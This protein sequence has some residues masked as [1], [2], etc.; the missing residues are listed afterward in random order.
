L[1]RGVIEASGQIVWVLG[2]EDQR[3]RFLRLLQLQK[4][5]LDYDG[6]YIDTRTELH[7]DDPAEV[8]SKINAFRE[9]IAPRHS[10]VCWSMTETILIG[11]PS[12]VE[13][14]RP[15]PVGCICGRNLG[16]GGS[17]AFAAASLR[18]PQNLL[19]LKSPRAKYVPNV[20][21]KLIPQLI[22]L[23]AIDESCVRALGRCWPRR[24]APRSR[25]VF[26]WFRIARPLTH[27]CCCG[28]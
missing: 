22:R 9:N 16:G 7:E 14:H 17:V 5:E 24:C 8:E 27:I 4:S 13:I 6:K 1:I 15:H 19:T 12:V 23:S 2:P 20:H 18:H 28:S 3:E 11:R 26:C 21:G 10:P 25:D